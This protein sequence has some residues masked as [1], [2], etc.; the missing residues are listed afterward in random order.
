MCCKVVIKLAKVF[1]D[2]KAKF[3]RQNES[4]AV[5][6]EEKLKIFSTKMRF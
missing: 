6:I 1:L 2:S 5:A 3:H 4:A